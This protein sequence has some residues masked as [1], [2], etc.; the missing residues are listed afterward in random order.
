MSRKWGNTSAHAQPGTPPPAKPRASPRQKYRPLTAPDPPAT[1]PRTTWAT[2]RG[3]SVSAV[4]N[5]CTRGLAAPMGSTDPSE[6][7]ARKSGSDTAGPAST[8]V[9]R[10]RSSA[11]NRSA[12]THPALPAPMIRMSLCNGWL[13]SNL[14]LQRP[15]M[16]FLNHSGPHPGAVRAIIQPLE[17][18]VR[19]LPQLFGLHVSVVMSAHPVRHAVHHGGDDHD[20]PEPPEDNREQQS[21]RP[22]VPANRGSQLQGRRTQSAYR[23]HRPASRLGF[24][25]VERPGH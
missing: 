21:D 7:I 24:H 14:W 2:R 1:A 18:H 6:I 15:G 19:H 20:V 4:S 10:H 8:T 16:P 17:S 23:Q 25:A 9:T 11:D 13:S 5:R 12:T 3:R 22:I